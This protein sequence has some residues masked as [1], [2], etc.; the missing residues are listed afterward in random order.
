MPAAIG[1]GV[2]ECIPLICLQMVANLACTM[3]PNAVPIVFDQ[4]RWMSEN[5]IDSESEMEI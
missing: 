1:S 2:K 5:K 3:N 4:Y